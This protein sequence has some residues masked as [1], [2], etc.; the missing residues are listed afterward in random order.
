LNATFIRWYSNYRH[1]CSSCGF[2]SEKP[3]KLEA[4]FHTSSDAFPDPADLNKSIEN[5]MI[6]DDFMTDKNRDP[7]SNYFT[8]GCTAN[9]DSLYLSQTYTKLPLHT[10]R[11]NSNIMI[12]FKSSPLVVNQLFMNYASVD[13]ELKEFKELCK[14]YWNEKY[15][16][17]LI[18]LTRDFESGLKYR[19]KLEL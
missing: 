8:R 4:E 19:N 18:D 1:C 14:Y 7:A 15:S 17:L 9:C 5:L 11:L 16:Y 10:V 12:F 6:F 3:S 13:M 2:I